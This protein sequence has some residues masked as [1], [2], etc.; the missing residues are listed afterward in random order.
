[1]LFMPTPRI[2][3]R[4]PRGMAGG[5][6]STLRAWVSEVESAGIDGVFSGD[7]VS[8]HDGTGYDGLIHATAVAAASERL[9]IWTAVYLLA[10]RHPVPVARQV[11]SLSSLAPGRFMFGVGLGG[12]DPHE[13]EICGVDPRRRGRRLDAHLDV[14]RA[15]LAGEE[16]TVDDEF[17]SIP[18]AIIRPIPEPAVPIL[19]GGRS[20]AA[21]K[22]TA[23]AGD[24]WIGIW[25]SPERA[26]AALETIGGYADKYGRAKPPDRN[27]LMVWCGLGDS[28]EHGRSLVA[29]V[30]EGIYKTP[31]ARFEK[32][33]P[34]GTP[35]DVAAA[36]A[37]FVAVG[38]NDIMLNGV[39]EDEAAVIAL[40]A[41]VGH[42]LSGG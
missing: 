20:G 29:P 1:M 22:R 36:L 40:S 34:C 12:E 31:F 10:L 23:R 17:L 16:V 19:V 15:L 35:A 14:V 27:I 8:F 32:Y 7:H 24:G 26:K 30:M 38:F 18:A 3:I 6:A 21:L 4:T 5:N 2:I 39:A 33:T 37:P 11:A 42:H 41:E 9:T 28:V 13:V 25:V